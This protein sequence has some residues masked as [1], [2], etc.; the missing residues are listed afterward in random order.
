M[1]RGA[2]PR[3]DCSRIC[4]NIIATDGTLDR[5]LLGQI[6]FKDATK[7][8]QLENIIHP[9]VRQRMKAD[10]ETLKDEG[11]T[12]VT[13]CD[14]PLLFETGMNLEAFDRILVVYATRERQKRRLMERNQLSEEEAELRIRSQIPT[15]HKV[16]RAD[17]VIDNSGSLEDTL[18][19]VDQIWDTWQRLISSRC[20]DFRR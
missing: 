9:R 1:P 16:R 18:R 17:D 3:G 6:V 7:R 5:R 2:C 19:Q 4:E 15:E 13:I 8:K 12:S 20:R 11:K 10:L 14:I